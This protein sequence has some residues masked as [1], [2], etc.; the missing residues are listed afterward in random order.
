MPATSSQLCANLD[1][2]VTEGDTHPTTPVTGRSAYGITDTMSPGSISTRPPQ[3]TRPIAL[4]TLGEGEGQG[5]GEKGLGDALPLHPRAELSLPG[6]T[7]STQAN[8]HPVR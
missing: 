5:W 6:L 3:V 1:P 2:G 8:T 7:L 4:A